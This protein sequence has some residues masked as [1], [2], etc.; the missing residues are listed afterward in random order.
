MRA[1]RR[2]Q[3]MIGAQRGEPALGVERGQ[4][5]AA[6]VERAAHVGDVHPPAEHRLLLVVPLQPLDLDGRRRAAR[7]G[8]AHRG[9][10]DDPGAEADDERVVPR[11]ARC[12]RR[13]VA[14]AAASSG[15]ASSSSCRPAGVRLTLRRSRS[16]SL[17]AEL[18]L[19]RLDLPA[20]R[21]LGDVQRF[22][23]AAEMQLLGDRDE[24]ADLDQI[25]VCDAGIVSIATDIGLGRSR[26]CAPA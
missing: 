18:L 11:A 13:R 26:R 6:L 5:Q 20:Q 3:R 10:G 16:S 17:R 9:G 24:P 22:G 14:S 21:R 19:E 7:R 23:G 15:T 12:T 2:R 8:T 1:S 4:L 25:E